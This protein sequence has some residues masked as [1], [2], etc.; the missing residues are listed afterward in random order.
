MSNR[1]LQLLKNNTKTKMAKAKCISSNTKRRVYLHPAQRKWAI[2]LVRL[3]FR[4]RYNVTGIA[5]PEFCT[6]CRKSNAKSWYFVSFY[7]R[8]FSASQILPTPDHKRQWQGNKMFVFFPHFKKTKY[9]V[10]CGSNS[11]DLKTVLL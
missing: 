5:A 2:L 10:H 6:E 9:C 8:F 3:A 4:N 1:C 11:S 7:K